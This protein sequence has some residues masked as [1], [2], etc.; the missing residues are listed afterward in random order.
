[1]PLPVVLPTDVEFPCPCPFPVPSCSHAV[2]TAPRC[3]DHNATGGFVGSRSGDWSG[4]EL[5]G[6][7][8]ALAGRALLNGRGAVETPGNRA[9]GISRNPTIGTSGRLI[10]G[11]P[12]FLGDHPERFWGSRGVGDRPDREGIQH[13]HG[14]DSPFLLCFEISKEDCELSCEVT[15]GK[16][17]LLLD[18]RMHEP[19]QNSTASK[20]HLVKMLVFRHTPARK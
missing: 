3:P 10:R 8:S 18:T 5:V 17:L 19:V 2:A 15:G 14:C 4:E 13:H 20:S 9:I 12:M 6:Y 16:I 11:H 1:M 7:P